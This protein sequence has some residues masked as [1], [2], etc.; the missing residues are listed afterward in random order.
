[1]GRKISE[2]E[3]DVFKQKEQCKCGV[4]VDEQLSSFLRQGKIQVPKTQLNPQI[5][6][7]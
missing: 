2:F 1:M 3:A 7:K 4:K 6:K 5:I